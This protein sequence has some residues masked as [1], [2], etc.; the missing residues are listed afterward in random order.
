MVEI[1][2]TDFRVSQQS[3]PGGWLVEYNSDLRISALECTP[4]SFGLLSPGNK[5]IAVSPDLYDAE[6]LLNFSCNYAMAR[7]FELLISF[8]YDL[9]TRRG[10]A[11]LLCNKPGTQEVRVEYG[12][13]A[14]NRF[15][16]LQK[17]S[18]TADEEAF[19]RPMPLRMLLEKQNLTV[20]FLDHDWNFQCRSDGRPGKFALSRGHFFDVLKI[21]AFALHAP[22]LP[23]CRDVHE[24]IVTLPGEATLY[25]VRVKVS[26]RDFGDC[27]EAQLQWEGGVPETPAGEGNYHAMRAD[28]LTRPFFKVIEPHGQEK[29]TLYDGQMTLVVE[30]L[31]PVEFYQVLH[32]RPEWPLKRRFFFRKPAGKFSLA[33][34]ADE[35]RH[36]TAKTKAMKP[37]ETIFNT[38]GSIEYTGSG[39][40]DGQINIRF[41]SQPEK[42]IAARLPKQDPRFQ[43]AIDF[44][45]NNHYFLEGEKI[46]FRCEI[47]CSLALPEDFTISLENAFLETLRPLPFELKKEIRR[48]GPIQMQ[49]AVCHCDELRGLAPGVYHLRCRSCDDSVMTVENYC[50]LEVMNRASDAL[51]PPLL[52]GLPF[53]YC[54]RTETRGLTT[55]AFDPWYHS[56]V[57]EGHYMA[58]ANFLP[59]CARD[60]QIAPTVHAYQREWFLWLGSRC[61][62]KPR[63]ADNQD[64]L[65]QAD[66]ANIGDEMG[67]F[68]LLWLYQYSEDFLELVLEFL[69]QTGDARFPLREIEETRQKGEFL[70]RESFEI[71]ARDY[72]PQWLDFANAKTYRKRQKFLQDIR[73]LNPKIRLANYGPAHIYAA[74]YKGQEF[75]RYLLNDHLTPGEQGFWQYED[76]P[77]ACRYGI[78]RGTYFLTAALMA[79]PGHRIYPEIYTLGIQGCP[80]GA[81]FYAHPPFGR[82]TANP[83]LRIRRRIFD[84]A[85]ASAHFQ[86]GKGF[87]FWR[88]YGFQ[89]CGFDRERYETLLKAWRV[90]RDYPPLKP[91]RSNAYVFSEAAWQANRSTTVISSFHDGG[92]VDVRKTAAESVPYAYEMARRQSLLAGFQTDME[93]LPE[94]SENHC[95]LLVLP[96]LTGA[97]QASL[98]AIRRL[99]QN[100]VN[101]LAFED[102]QGLEDLFG[103]KDTGKKIFVQQLR[104]TS[105]FLPGES[106]FCDEPL[107]CGQYENAGAEVLLDAE[108]PVLLRHR[109]ASANAVFCNVPP[110]LVRDDQLHHRLGYGCESISGLMNNAIGLIISQLSTPA[111]CCTAGRLVAFQAE[112]QACVIIAANPDEENEI[113]PVLTIQKNSPRQKMFSCDQ[114]YRILQESDTQLCMR[115][116]LAREDSAVIVLS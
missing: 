64:L 100:G 111:I 38:D 68:S 110:T 54:S 77:M 46:Q 80:D 63:I 33:V 36:T 3:V 20:T 89:A 71:L 37:A 74:H 101:L 90:V 32:K 65:A 58:A 49:V 23:A 24:F 55:D 10:E 35:Y 29:Y 9:N 21:T 1:F 22:D 14:D 52:S 73:R 41:F 15:T 116:R 47:N 62:D 107:C 18:C 85:F 31:A 56:D 59:K 82:R 50:A 4:D 51:P 17:Q 98:A 87:A 102:V 53:L 16:P 12:T 108:I 95:D 99:H 70:D 96:P 92:I 78:E 61:A 57:D 69:R 42:E 114:P 67:V 75:V 39:I 25:P 44:T 104:G 8:R 48:I 103:V 94:L 6:L 112:N 43:Q 88:K 34:G 86:A 5:Y 115:V 19:S 30:E 76:Y 83:P 113:N 66:Y 79:L 60:N 27:C 26:L 97:S 72:W 105:G 106:E 84:Y 93:A 13:I 91:L 2:Q 81:V 11:L 7:Q 109:N 45:R 40:S 28:Q